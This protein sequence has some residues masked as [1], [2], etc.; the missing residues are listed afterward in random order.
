MNPELILQQYVFPSSSSWFINY[1]NF[2]ETQQKL[3]KC[4]INF[5]SLRSLI[6]GAVLSN[7]MGTSAVAL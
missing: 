3:E 6:V 7:V 2:S 4:C 1:V 5:W